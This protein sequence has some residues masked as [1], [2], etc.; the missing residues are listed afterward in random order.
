MEE[1]SCKKIKLDIDSYIDKRNYANNFIDLS[2]RDEKKLWSM[3]E[4]NQLISMYASRPELWNAKSKHY[5]NRIKKR[6]AFDEIAQ[7]FSVTVDEIYRKMH[8][9]RTQFNN[10]LR[11]TK[12]STDQPVGE[13]YVSKWPYFDSL[14]FLLG[15]T[16]R[17][18]AAN[19]TVCLL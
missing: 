3:V 12:R 4:T 11:K 2:Y 5:K 14:K 16:E 13:P 8:N 6:Q 7:T 15:C 9:L 1:M 18:S 10:E 17:K 19:N